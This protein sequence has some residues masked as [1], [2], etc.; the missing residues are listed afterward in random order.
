MANTATIKKTNWN[1]PSSEFKKI[2]RNKQTADTRQMA[3]NIRASSE[4]SGGYPRHF[5]Q[6]VCIV[7]I[8]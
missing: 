8:Q 1:I 6:K 2:F 4:K 3:L 7:L 5:F